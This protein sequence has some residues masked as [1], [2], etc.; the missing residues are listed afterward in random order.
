[1]SDSYR[2]DVRERQGYH[3][4]Q[5]LVTNLEKSILRNVEAVRPG[6]PQ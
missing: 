2:R 6:G 5:N 4:V 3:E 1:M